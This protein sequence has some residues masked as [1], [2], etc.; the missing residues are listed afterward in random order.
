MRKL[1]IT[2]FAVLMSALAILAIAGLGFSD[3]AQPVA[4]QA[5]PVMSNVSS[6]APLGTHSVPPAE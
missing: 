6:A 3:D 4:D 5:A 1:K 2:V